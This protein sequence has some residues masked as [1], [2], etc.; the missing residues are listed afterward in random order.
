MICILDERNAK[1]TNGKITA[2]LFVQ[3]WG[4]ALQITFRDASG[5]ILLREISNGGALTR[6]ARKF[7]STAGEMYHLTVSFESD[8]K[9]KIYGMGQ[10]QQEIYQLRSRNSS[11][12][13]SE[14]FQ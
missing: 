6:K 9:E 3:E 5:K 8:S 2:E 4:N 7:R 12:P 10:Y 1:I 14:E 11:Q 13:V